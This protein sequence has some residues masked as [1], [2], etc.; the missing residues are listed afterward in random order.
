MRTRPLTPA[1][2]IMLM[3]FILGAATPGT[4]LAGQA[5][6]TIT[7]TNQADNL[8]GTPGDDVICGFGGG[9][10]IRGKN[11][12]DVV[13]GGDGGD[14]IHGGQGRDSL[15][16]GDGSDQLDPG[17]GADVTRGGAGPDF[18]F[19]SSAGPDQWFGGPGP[20]HLTDFNGLDRI[21]GGSGDDS[22][23]ATFD[24]AGGD[25]LIG[26]RGFDI[27]FADPADDVRGVE[28]RLQCFAQ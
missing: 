19:V 15:L 22:C 6:C 20:D 5:G 23:L 3:A 2:V 27:W 28:Q 17:R 13:R 11:G 9:D 21:N 4:V 25:I 8:G 14:T 16:G 10:T 1:V 12:D 18:S 24:Q 26:G 7:G